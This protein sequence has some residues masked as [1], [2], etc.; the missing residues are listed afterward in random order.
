[1]TIFNVTYTNKGESGNVQLKGVKI[2]ELRESTN[3]TFS[4][5]YL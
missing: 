1:M 4:L 2:K 5:V 3:K